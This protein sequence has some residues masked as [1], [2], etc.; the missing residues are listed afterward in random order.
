MKGDE[1][2][3]GPLESSLSGL[4]LGRVNALLLYGI[5][6]VYTHSS[7]RTGLGTYL[8]IAVGG[9]WW[10]WWWVAA[11]GGRRQWAVAMGSGQWSGQWGGRGRGRVRMGGRAMGV[12]R[13]TDNYRPG[14][15]Q[16]QKGSPPAI[17]CVTWGPI[18]TSTTDLT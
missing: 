3:R 9:G 5:A 18:T 1:R 15:P 2:M 13:Q 4:G 11:G 17:L 10:W 14:S 7:T 6:G 16:K 8:G 12:P